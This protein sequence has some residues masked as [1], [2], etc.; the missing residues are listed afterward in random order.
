MKKIG[1]DAKIIMQKYGIVSQ[2]KLYVSIIQKQWDF[3]KLKN[4]ILPRILATKFLLFKENLR[5]EI[6]IFIHFL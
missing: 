3:K 4:Y 2:I 5:I 6:F 1:Q